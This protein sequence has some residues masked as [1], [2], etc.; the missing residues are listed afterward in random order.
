MAKYFIPIF[1]GVDS[2]SRVSGV[3]AFP[4]SK[5]ILIFVF[6]LSSFHMI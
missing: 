4:I 3:G 5:D 1:E 2:P 6:D